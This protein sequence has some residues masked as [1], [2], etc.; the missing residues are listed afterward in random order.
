[1]PSIKESYTYLA[2]CL[3]AIKL[4]SS[5]IVIVNIM[6]LDHYQ[7]VVSLLSLSYYAIIIIKF[8]SNCKQ[9]GL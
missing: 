7:V 3:Q 1:M 6:P 4:L 9:L 2:D 5:Q 8:L